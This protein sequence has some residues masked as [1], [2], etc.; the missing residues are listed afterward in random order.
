MDHLNFLVESPRNIAVSVAVVATTFFAV[1]KI[2]GRSGGRH[3]MKPAVNSTKPVL[4][5]ISRWKFGPNCSPG[6]VAAETFLRIAGIPHDIDKSL[7]PGPTER[8]PFMEY[9]GEYVCETNTIVDVLS[10]DYHFKNDDNLTD[11]EKA[12]AWVIL[13]MLEQGTYFSIVRHRWVDNVKH[14]GQML[15][16]P[17]FPEMLKPTIMNQGRKMM[18]STLNSQGAGD[19]TDEE[20]HQNTMK[21][22]KAIEAMMDDG[23]YFFDRLRTPL[24]TSYE[25]R[26]YG[27]LHS[28][29]V[30]DTTNEAGK[31][32]VVAFIKGSARLQKFLKRIEAAAFPDMD[33][34][35]K[36]LDGNRE[37]WTKSVDE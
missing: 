14:Y 3:K 8:Y 15:N 22:L 24:P 32:E 2:F 31:W 9:K 35:T 23:G 20:Y 7:K 4:H 33:V 34:I 13:R 19:L 36:R 5:I 37:S 16:F 28:L 18:I 30:F 21:D 25:A 17:Q 12:K 27:Y 10:E 29:E 26:Y 6:C 11:E 1:K